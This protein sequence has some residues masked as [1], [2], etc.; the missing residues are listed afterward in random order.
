MISVSYKIRGLPPKVNL[1][2]VSH[3]KLLGI[4]FIRWFKSEWTWPTL[5][6]IIGNAHTSIAGDVFIQG[7]LDGLD[8][9]GGYKDWTWEYSLSRVSS[10]FWLLPS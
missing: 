6:R 4:A 9:K 8:L 7:K 1:I 3:T 2:K 10:S 5:R